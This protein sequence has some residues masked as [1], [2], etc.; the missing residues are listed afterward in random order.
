MQ[1]EY[2]YLETSQYFKKHA[3]AIKTLS[4]REKSD[5][6]KIYKWQPLFFIA[7]SDSALKST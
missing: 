4:S 7:D 2:F 3:S 5:S 1:G 6:V